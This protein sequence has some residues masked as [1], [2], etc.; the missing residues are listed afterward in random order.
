MEFSSKPR[1]QAPSFNPV[2]GIA[3]TLDGVEFTCRGSIRLFELSALSRQARDGDQ[4]AAASLL[5]ESLV[6]AL[7]DKEYA[8]FYQHYRDHQTPDDTVTEICA[9]IDAEA[10]KRAADHAERPTSPQ[11]TLQPGLP[12]QAERMSRIVSLQGGDVTVLRPGDQ[13][14]TD[15]MPED[16]D[17][18]PPGLRTKKPAKTTPR[19]RGAATG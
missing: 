6:Q 8:R 5:A 12:E 4:A 15:T 2:E 10:Q 13:G 19:S 17:R 9:Y 18:V 16:P 3:F 11:P 7:G 1:A 14:Y